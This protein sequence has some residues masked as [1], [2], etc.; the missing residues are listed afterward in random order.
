MNGD[1]DAAWSISYR[2]AGHEVYQTLPPIV[3]LEHAIEA[4]R[5]LSKCKKDIIEIKIEWTYL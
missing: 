4:V 2:I 5:V 3:E 1:R